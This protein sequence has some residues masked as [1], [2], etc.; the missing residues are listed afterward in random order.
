MSTI[1]VIAATGERIL[2]SDPKD[3][4]QLVTATGRAVIVV[5]C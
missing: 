4:G 2:K 3:I 1:V 5:G